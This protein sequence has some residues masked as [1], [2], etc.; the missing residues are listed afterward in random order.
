M[1]R[2][3]ARGRLNATCRI[4]APVGRHDDLVSYLVRRLLENGANTSFVNRLADDQ[5]H[6]DEIL[7]D[8]CRPWSASAASPCACCRGRWTSSRPSA[9]NSRGIALTEPDRAG[10]ILAGGGDRAERLLR[11]GA[12][13]RRRSCAATRRRSC[14]L[15]PHDR[16]ERIGVVHT[17][18]PATIETALRNAAVCHPS[19][20][21]ARRRSPG[22]DPG[23]GR[24]I[25][26]SATARA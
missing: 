18:D 9:L 26:T 22:A 12:H 3:S 21:P 13:R 25:S 4:Y 23:Q 15:C 17:A 7:R 19:M 2:S 24:R 8:P 1:T 11:G 14:V 6:L 10:R 5:T 16:R 20:G